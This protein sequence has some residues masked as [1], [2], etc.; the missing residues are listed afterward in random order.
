MPNEATGATPK[1][2]DRAPLAN[3]AF[4]VESMVLLF[5]LVAALAVFTQVFASSVSN[6]A[7][8]NR[9]SAAT[10]VAQNAAEEFSANPV[11]VA[12]N[13]AVGA[14]IA[15]DGANGF[16]VNCDVTSENNDAGTLY[17]AHIEVSDDEGV[18][19][20]LDAASF[21]AGGAH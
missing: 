2:R 11:A 10:E 21:V 9:L 7:E 4:L 17:S 6:S 15:S 18:A 14:G 13:R 8:A 16:S 20:E 5:F 3:T 12:Q 19:Y 1:K